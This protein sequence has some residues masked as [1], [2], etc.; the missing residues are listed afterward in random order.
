MKKRSGELGVAT[1]MSM[2]DEGGPQCRLG[3]LL[4]IPQ[5]SRPSAEMGVRA[6]LERAG[7]RAVLSRDAALCGTDRGLLF[8][9]RGTHRRM[10]A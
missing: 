2:S 6:H 7:N 1:V 5:P 9:S 3:G 10:T 8:C 4:S